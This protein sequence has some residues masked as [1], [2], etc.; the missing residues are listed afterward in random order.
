LPGRPLVK[1]FLVAADS[2]VWEHIKLFLQGV[3]F[4]VGVL[5]WLFWQYLVDLISIRK[6]L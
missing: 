3:V 4:L 2:S 6:S 1:P 5:I